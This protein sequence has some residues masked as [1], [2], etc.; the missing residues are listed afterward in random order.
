MSSTKRIIEY[1][2]ARLQDKRVEVRLNAIQEL[3]LLQASEALEAL[4]LVFE[5]DAD[6]S[7]RKSAQEAGRTIYKAIKFA[8]QSADQQTM[9]A[10]DTA[11]P[12]SSPATS[13]MDEVS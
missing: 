1:H 2:I 5:N 4:Q 6:E 8:S 13:G 12:S 10:T 7:V 11:N 3:V 9:D